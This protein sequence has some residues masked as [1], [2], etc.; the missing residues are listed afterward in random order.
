MKYEGPVGLK[1]R[2]RKAQGF[3]PEAYTQLGHK[4]FCTNNLYN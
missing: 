1:G 2:P 3:S 4:Y